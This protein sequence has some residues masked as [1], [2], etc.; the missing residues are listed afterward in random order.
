MK[1]RALKRTPLY[2][3]YKQYGEKTKVIDFGGWALPVQFSSILAEH[4][5]VR[6]EAGLFD[7]SHMGEIL[8]EGKDAESFLNRL[9]TNDVTKLQI[10]QAQYTAMCDHDGGT[11]DDLLVYRLANQKYMLVVNAANLKNDYTWLKEH[12]SG[13]VTLQNISDEVALLAIQG[14]KAIGIL[15]KVTE[16][17]L[18]KLAPFRFAQSVTIAG[19]SDVLI[20]RTGYTGEDGFELYLGANKAKALWEKLLAVGKEDGLKPCGLG[21]RDTLRFE[22]CL[23]LYGRELSNEITPLEAGI[24]FAVKLNKNC[25]FIGKEQLFVNKG[26]RKLVGIEVTERAIPRHGYKVYSEDG[27]IG[28]ITSGTFSPTL[29][30]SLGLALIPFD[31]AEVGTKL[32]VQIRNKFIDAIVVKTPFYKKR[33]V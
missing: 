19:I 22:A 13:D 33:N 9:V 17:E 15:Q 31:Y 12:A 28:F 18:I 14:P 32:K 25:P 4:E 26:K 24:G 3:F 5:A 30:K 29:K 27:E 6:N 11:I 23:P 20:S 10:N 8:I 7:V 2:D 16:L 21:A 1:E